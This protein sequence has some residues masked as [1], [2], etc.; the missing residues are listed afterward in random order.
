MQ[1][2]SHSSALG[3]FAEIGTF[4]HEMRCNARPAKSTDRLYRGT[5]YGTDNG[6]GFLS[7]ACQLL[8]LCSRVFP[9]VT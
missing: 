6:S 9:A 1:M 8:R 2:H 3:A 4:W 7:N 5:T